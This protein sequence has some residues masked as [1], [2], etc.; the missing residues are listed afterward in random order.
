M[1][2]YELYHHGIL[3]MKWGIRRF[4]NKDGSLTA[5]GKQRYRTD[6][7]NSGHTLKNRVKSALGIYKEG[8]GN[9]YVSEKRREDRRRQQEEQAKV[10]AQEENKNAKKDIERGQWYKT[11]NDATDTFNPLLEKLNER[12]GDKADINDPNYIEAVGNLWNGIYSESIIKRYGGG[13]SQETIENF[14]MYNM[15]LAEI[16]RK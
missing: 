10:K 8:D 16:K 11:Y 3:G 4:Q 7:D 14:P 5:A 12:L 2:D 1:N 15:Y 6:N 13:V 9:P